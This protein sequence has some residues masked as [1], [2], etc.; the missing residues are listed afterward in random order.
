MRNSLLFI[1][2]ATALIAGCGSPDASPPDASPPDASPPDASP[3]TREELLA[4]SLLAWQDLKAADDG[5]YQ[6]TRSSSSFTGAR[7]TTTFVVE[8]DVVVRR[9]FEG[10]DEDG[11]LVESFDEEGA[12]VGS[13]EGAKPA[14]TI[15]ELYEICRTEVLTQDPASN[16]FYLTF[17]DD[18]VFELCTYVPDDCADDC[19]EGVE[20]DSL[21]MSL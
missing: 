20:I 7:S 14:H 3:P 16:R 1:G 10:Y 6:Y 17:R 19:S 11:V 2:L 9:S 13:N 15:D 12:D 5:T 4:E 8:A 21:D 18:G